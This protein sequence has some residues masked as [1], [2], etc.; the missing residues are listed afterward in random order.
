METT[1][2][3][4]ASAAELPVLGQATDDPWLGAMTVCGKTVGYRST[5]SARN[6]VGATCQACLERSSDCKSQPPSRKEQSTKGTEGTGSDER[7]TSHT[8][9]EES[10]CAEWCEACRKEW[11]DR[12]DERIIDANEAAARFACHILGI[13][14]ESL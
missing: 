9:D 10:G 5:V 13:D 7:S 4:F 1:L 6:P 11:N 3:I 14:P 8:Y 2:H 12:R